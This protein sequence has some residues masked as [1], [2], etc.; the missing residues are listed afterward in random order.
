[1]LPSWLLTA[2][3]YLEEVREPY[4]EITVA[5]TV[6]DGPYA[7]SDTPIF[8]EGSLTWTDLDGVV[9]DEGEAPYEDLPG[10]WVGQLPV[11]TEYVLRVEGPAHHPAI[12]RGRTSDQPML[13]YGGTVFSWPAEQVDPLLDDVAA[14]LGRT[15]AD[16]GDGERVHLWGVPLD[17]EAFEAAQA[18]VVGGDGQAAE[19]VAFR[20][21]SNGTW[22]E[23]QP[24][25]PVDLF[26]CFDLA[27]G[28]VVLR[29]GGMDIERWPTRGGDLVAAWWLEVP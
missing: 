6:Y 14:S 8:T 10:Y 29:Y 12:F 16:L 2:C 3:S 27:P 28:D 18:E 17:P 21:A 22:L 24:G 4:T 26:F 20:I 1:M 19:L 15:V 25:E 23:A 11:G 5:G 7:G 9:L 13:W